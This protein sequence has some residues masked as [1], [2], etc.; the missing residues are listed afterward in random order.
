MKI[1]CIQHVEFETLGTIVEWIEK[2]NHSLSITRLYENQNF[3]SLDRFD[4]LI[5]MGGPMN[6]YEYE[7]YPWLRKEKNISQRSYFCRKSSTWNLPWRS[8]YC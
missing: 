7:K 6:I 3:P 4:L 1:Y 8:A 2:R 5:V